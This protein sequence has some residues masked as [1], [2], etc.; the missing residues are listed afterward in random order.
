MLDKL[1]HA[2]VRG[3]GPSPNPTAS[4]DPGPNSS[5][6]PN[7]NPEPNSNPDPTPTPTPQVCDFGLSRPYTLSREA[8][9]DLDLDPVHGTSNPNQNL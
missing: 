2:K 7:P 9:A 8:L 3:P 6:G 4:L 1:Q 5:P